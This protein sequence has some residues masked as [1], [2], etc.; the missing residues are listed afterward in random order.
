MTKL[1]NEKAVCN[2]TIFIKNKLERKKNMSIL[3]LKNELR[4]VYK[5][6]TNERKISTQ[7]LYKILIELIFPLK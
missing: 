3:A 7:I 1:I 4:K 6:N 2:V 5:I